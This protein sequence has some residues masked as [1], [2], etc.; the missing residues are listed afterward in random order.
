MRS[1]LSV[2][3]GLVAALLGSPAAVA[4]DLHAGVGSLGD[5]HETPDRPGGEALAPLLRSRDLEG[6]SFD[7]ER[8]LEDRPVLLVVWFS[9]CPTCPRALLRLLDWAQEQAVPPQVVGVNGDSAQ[10]RAWLRPF[11]QRSELDLT[12]L[13][14]PA[15]DLRRGLGLEQSPAVVLIEREHEGASMV[16]HQPAGGPISMDRLARGWIGTADQA[17]AVALA[18]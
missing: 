12:V 13:A 9:D 17:E 16:R 3:I 2:S 11:L 5:A 15:G 18:R 14:D 10:Q 8:A 1:P 6:R 4:G 7:L